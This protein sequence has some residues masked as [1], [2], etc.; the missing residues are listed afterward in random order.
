MRLLVEFTGLFLYVT[1]DK[2][3]L[4]VL[5]P[6]TP[7]EYCHTV[8]LQ[9]IDG[10]A[11]EP[12]IVLDQ[13]RL[14]F[15]GKGSQSISPPDK[16]PNL[17]KRSGGQLRETLLGDNPVDPS[18]QCR[19]T[20]RGVDNITS[21][22]SAFFDIPGSLD[23]FHRVIANAVYCDLG[24]FNQPVTIEATDLAGT[25]TQSYTFDND[26]ATDEDRIY[27][28]ISHARVGELARPCHKHDAGE[29]LQHYLSLYSLFTGCEKN[30]QPIFRECVSPTPSRPWKLPEKLPNRGDV[31]IESVDPVTCVGGGG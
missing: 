31:C 17:A 24:T 3:Q 11:D 30:P 22:G 27:L 23:R 1:R 29:K 21:Q 26:P 5:A 4:H 9:V 7:D 14:T 12:R 18:L 15:E 10:L 16:L 19:I 13:M 2:S 20:V 25:G 6:T 8:V 28:R